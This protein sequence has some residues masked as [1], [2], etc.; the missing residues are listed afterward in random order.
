MAIKPAYTTLVKYAKS[1]N[2]PTVKQSGPQFNYSDIEEKVL[3]AIQATENP[4]SLPFNLLLYYNTHPEVTGKDWTGDEAFGID[5]DD[6]ETIIKQEEQI[7]KQ[8]RYSP[9]EI[10]P[11]EE[12]KEEFTTFGYKP[13]TLRGKLDILI[14]KQG[15]RRIS[16]L[17]RLADTT[18][19]EVNY[20]LKSL[21]TK[22]KIKYKV[23]KDQYV[24]FGDI[25]EIE[26][27]E[28]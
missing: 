17:A 16:E 11:E 3:N 25:L 9:E 22:N 12:K 7:G 14:I 26:I 24:S 6:L 13:M 15:V 27:L 20:F 4:E 2:I 5:T 23:K 21:Q 19:Q 28:Q 18:K 8:L 1:L 10:E